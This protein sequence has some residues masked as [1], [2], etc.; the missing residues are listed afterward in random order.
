MDIY[1][2]TFI[3]Q[4]IKKKTQLAIFNI[5]RAPESFSASLYFEFECSAFALVNVL[6]VIKASMLFVLHPTKQVLVEM[7]CYHSGLNLLW[8][9]LSSSMC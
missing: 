8:K 7:E 1:I 5:E 9:L 3:D 6:S 4:L 2:H